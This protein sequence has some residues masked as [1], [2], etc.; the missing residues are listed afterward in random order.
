MGDIER[1][2]IYVCPVCRKRAQLPGDPPMCLDHLNPERCE[3]VI[4][5]VDDTEGAVGLREEIG[6]LADLWERSGDAR[7]IAHSASLRAILKAHGGQ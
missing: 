4:V 3:A 7:L 2:T 6:R 1:W 5:R